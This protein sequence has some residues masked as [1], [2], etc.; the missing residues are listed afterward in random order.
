[1]VD[2]TKSLDIRQ[3]KPLIDLNLEI[4]TSLEE[5][6]GKN[7]DGRGQ[8]IG[9]KTVTVKANFDTKASDVVKELKK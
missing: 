4:F 6:E 7:V 8:T 3:I 1:M 9:R 2:R 5:V